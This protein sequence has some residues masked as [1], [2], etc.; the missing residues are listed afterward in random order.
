MYHLTAASPSDTINITDRA[1][2]TDELLIVI[3]D[4]TGNRRPRV[5]TWPDPGSAAP[6]PATERHQGAF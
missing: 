1:G 4:R 5:R 3:E 2:R 6:Q